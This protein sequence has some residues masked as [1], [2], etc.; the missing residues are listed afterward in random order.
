MILR[1]IFIFY[2]FSFADSDKVT[3][4]LLLVCIHFTMLHWNAVKIKRFYMYVY[5]SIP[6]KRAFLFSKCFQRTW[7]DVGCQLPGLVISNIDIDIDNIDD[8]FEV[9]ISISAILS[10]KSIDR[11][12]DDTLLAF[13]LSTLHRYLSTDM[14][15]DAHNFLSFRA[16]VR[17]QRSVKIC[18]YKELV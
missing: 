12:I 15:N 13:F 10:Y 14:Q 18:V 9:S 4:W 7:H 16:F 17:V 1:I 5:I 6:K 8:T 2:K 11:G 3:E